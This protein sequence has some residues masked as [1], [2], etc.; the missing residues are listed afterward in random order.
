MKDTGISI[1]GNL[2][3]IFHSELEKKKKK[4][5][6]NNVKWHKQALEMPKDYLDK[7]L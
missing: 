6:R 4:K 3:H 5:S 7:I 2:M 1:E